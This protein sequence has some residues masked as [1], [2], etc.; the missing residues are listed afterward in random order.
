MNPQVFQEN[1][2]AWFDRYGRKDLPWQL[3]ATPYHIWVSEIMLQQTRVETVIPYYLKFIRYYPDVNVLAQSSLDSVLHL[4]SGLGYYA[5]ARNMHKAAQL[6]YE[7]R[8][9]P[10]NL[11]SLMQLPGIGQSTAGAILS[12]AFHKRHPILDGNVKRVLARFRGV[13]G[14]PG[15][16]AVSKTLWRISETLTPVERVADYTQAMMDLG[17]IICAR[18]KPQCERCPLADSCMAKKE[19]RIS[20]LPA[21]KPKKQLPHKQCAFLIL[22]GKE[23]QVILE[24][25]PEAGIWGGLWC[26]P[27]FEN[28]DAA[29]SWCMERD[30]KVSCQEILAVQRHTFSHYH[31]DYTA[32]IVQTDHPANKVMEANRSLW[33]KADKIKTLGLPAP[34]KRLLEKTFFKYEV[35]E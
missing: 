34:V 27:E 4:W 8:K 21:P 5:R 22:L 17:A 30:I 6:I 33:Y 14:W 13:E 35:V 11:E 10:D 20:E 26:L 32:V 3:N 16:G 15:N 28:T 31:L 12:M 7:Q 18:S 19:G 2:L 9:F 1:V 29:L 25:R 24:R 23:G